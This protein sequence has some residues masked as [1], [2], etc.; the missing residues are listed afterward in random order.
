MLFFLSINI[1]HVNNTLLMIADIFLVK[2]TL[3]Q[4]SKNIHIFENAQIF[5]TEDW[6][7]F[8]NVSK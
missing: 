2:N 4:L 6:Q 8:Q 1:K 3:Y 5:I 7:K